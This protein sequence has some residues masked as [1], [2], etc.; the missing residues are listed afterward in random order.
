MTDHEAELRRRATAAGVFLAEDSVTLLDG[1]G[2]RRGFRDVTA[3]EAAELLVW[4]DGWTDDSVPNPPVPEGFELTRHSWCPRCERRNGDPLGRPADRRRY[5]VP[6][7]KPPPP[8]QSVAVPC[9]RL[10][11]C[12]GRFAGRCNTRRLFR[13]GLRRMRPQLPTWSDMT[14]TIKGDGTETTLIV[15][16]INW[17]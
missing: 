1:S 10:N 11:R 3:D 2:W 15:N 16:D 14:V 17:T 13:W 5:F 9:Q 7:I 8:R 6:W 12:G 4:L